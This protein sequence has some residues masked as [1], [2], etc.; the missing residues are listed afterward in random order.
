MSASLLLTAQPNSIGIAVGELSAIY[1]KIK[2][3]GNVSDGVAILECDIQFASLAAMC[4]RKPPVFA[5]HM[6]PNDSILPPGASVDDICCMIAALLE[7]RASPIAVQSR[8]VGAG[9]DAPDKGALTEALSA[10]AKENRL[11]I[12]NRHPITVISVCVAVGGVYIGVSE[13]RHNLCARGGRAHGFGRLEEKIS[14]S[15]LK[16]LEALETFDI[17]LPGEGRAIDLG[18]APGGWTHALAERG[19]SVDAVDPALL[20]AQLYA[21]ALVS[22]HRMTAQAYVG[23]ARPADVLVNDMRLDA[24]DS[25]ALMLAYRRMLKKG[26]IAIMTVKLP[27]NGAQGVAHTA[28]RT[29]SASYTVIGARQLYNNRSEVTVAMRNDG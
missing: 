22:H 15:E 7:G 27:E 3:V 10:L 9:E 29:L 12:D 28:I 1:N 19:L 2:R 23:S 13:A 11:E 21:N 8:F 25:C 24:R 6:C 4:M 17:T 16:L 14:R 5:Q 26:G 20:N 18:A